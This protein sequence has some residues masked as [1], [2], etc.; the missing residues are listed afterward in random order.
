MKNILLCAALFVGAA[1]IEAQDVE[2]YQEECHTKWRY[3]L[4]SDDVVSIPELKVQFVWNAKYAELYV[5]KHKKHLVTELDL[6]GEMVFDERE[7]CVVLAVY[8]IAQ[9]EWEEDNP[10]RLGKIG[11]IGYYAEV[12]QFDDHVELRVWRGGQVIF[13]KSWFS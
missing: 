13:K 12:Q 9:M 11:E 6:N 2:N 8:G 5:I 7:A 3:V 1:S 4:P 10:L